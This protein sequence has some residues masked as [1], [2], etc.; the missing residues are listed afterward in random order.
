MASPIRQEITLNAAPDEVFAA[1]TQSARFSEVTGQP[2][3][4]DA[5][6]GGAFSRF[7]DQ[8][9][10]RIIEMVPGRRLVEAWRVAPW[11]EGKYS[12]VSF[13]VSPHA[14]G[15]RLVL[16]QDGYPE[17]NRDHLES[18]WRKMYLQPLADFFAA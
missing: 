8:V 7:G 4:I 15:T 2:A 11:P 5:A 6:D 18:G 14:S 1:L 12:V 17:D 10:G 3:E 9:T 13:D 16:E